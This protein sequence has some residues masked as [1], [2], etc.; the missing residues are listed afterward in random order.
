MNFVRSVVNFFSGNVDKQVLQSQRNLLDNIHE[1]IEHN[2]ESEVALEEAIE[3][4]K[5]QKDKYQQRQ[6]QLKAGQ[7]ELLALIEVERLKNK[8]NNNTIENNSN[9]SQTVVQL[10][11]ASSDS[12][13]A[14]ENEASASALDSVATTKTQDVP[15]TTHKTYEAEEHYL[16]N[17]LPVEIQH[18]DE[19]IRAFETKIVVLEQKL[20]TLRQTRESAEQAS[21]ALEDQVKQHEQALESMHDSFN[22]SNQQNSTIGHSEEL[23]DLEAGQAN[24]V[25]ITNNNNTAVQA[26]LLVVEDNISYNNNHNNNTDNDTQEDTDKHSTYYTN[27]RLL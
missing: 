16:R 21:M 19:K 5:K 22:A 24:S 13:T 23:P 11:Q 17:V 9:N 14:G 26:P 25:N 1:Q 6:K 15:S 2:Y 7:A 20:Q 4:F 3:A 8:N 10:E 18:N 12:T 27:K